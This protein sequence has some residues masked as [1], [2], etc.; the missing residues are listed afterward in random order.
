MLFQPE[1]YSLPLFI[2]WMK[3]NIFVLYQLQYCWVEWRNWLKYVRLTRFTPW[4]SVQ[5][6]HFPFWLSCT[7]FCVA[8]LVLS[9]GNT[10][11][12][13]GCFL[14]MF[15]NSLPVC[16]Y[17]ISFCVFKY[18]TYEEQTEESYRRLNKCLS[19]LGWTAISDIR[20]WKSARTALNL[21]PGLP[22]YV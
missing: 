10:G 21:L 6:T 17:C 2:C 5:N 7:S 22:R 15:G 8:L 18:C 4:T 19:Y 13:W 20:C 3:R 1:S 16:L 11:R 12:K 9:E 14:I